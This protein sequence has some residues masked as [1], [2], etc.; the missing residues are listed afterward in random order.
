MKD[1]YK[2]MT[3]TFVEGCKSRKWKFWNFAF[4]GK[5]LQSNDKGTLVVEQKEEWSNP[6]ETLWET[7]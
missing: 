1:L 7:M 5:V 3:L 4:V 2:I 6:R